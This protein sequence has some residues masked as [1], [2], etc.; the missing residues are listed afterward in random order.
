M[1]EFLPLLTVIAAGIFFAQFLKPFGIPYVIVLLLSGMLIGPHGIDL[2]QPDETITFLGEIGLVFLMFMAGL[3]TKMSQMP[4]H[5]TASFALA[6]MNGFIPFIV[7][8]GI[9]LYLGYGWISALLLGTVFI[10]SSIAVIIPSLSSNKLLNKKIGKTI[11]GATV[12]EDSLS[13]IIF[14]FLLSAMV[15]SDVS[16]PVYYTLLFAFLFILGF[17]IRKIRDAYHANTTKRED[18]IYEDEIRFAFVV[19]LGSVFIFEL[20]GLHA[21]LAGFYAGIVL[22]GHEMSNSIKRKLHVLS[23]GFF[24]PIFFVVLGTETDLGILTENAEIGTILILI[25]LGSLLSK[26]ASGFLAGRLSRFSVK[27]SAI[28]GTSTV[29]QLS[30]TLAVAFTGYELGLFDAK[31]IMSLAILTI[32]SIFVGPLFLRY[33]IQK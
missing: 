15:P 18:E 10:S 8:L 2:F 4:S 23:Y 24:I 26:F 1:A 27:E 17:F 25:V 11:L 14:S 30:T 13:L 19:L 16:L 7:G 3:E 12:L 31:I 33:F 22:S 6:I 20:L 29:P 5:R 28:M 32:I 9:A 21:I